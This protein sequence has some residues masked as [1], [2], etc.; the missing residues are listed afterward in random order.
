MFT[1][2]IFDGELA[3]FID[4]DGE[5][6]VV[7]FGRLDSE[8]KGA[9]GKRVDFFSDVRRDLEFDAFVGVEGEEGVFAAVVIFF[10]RRVR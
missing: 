2:V 1:S 8:G 6:A 4:G 7:V 5:R 3:R 9:N 10:K